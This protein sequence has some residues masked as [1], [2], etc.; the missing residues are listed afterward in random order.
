MATLNTRN[1]RLDRRAPMAAECDGNRS[2]HL[3]QSTDAAKTHRGFVGCDI[4]GIGPI[5]LWRIIDKPRSGLSHERPRRSNIPIAAVFAGQSDSLGHAI[6]IN[7]DTLRD[8]RS[9]YPKCSDFG[10]ISNDCNPNF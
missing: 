7:D 3:L 8:W 1:S 2:R 10:P 4:V 5:G 9:N 6:P